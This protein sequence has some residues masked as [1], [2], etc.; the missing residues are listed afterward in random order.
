MAKYLVVKKF[1]E[2]VFGIET[3]HTEIS[4]IEVDDDVNIVSHWMTSLMIEHETDGVLYTNPL[5]VENILSIDFYLLTKASKVDT[6]QL[7]DLEKQF[8]GIV[9]NNKSIRDNKGK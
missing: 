8:D 2:D 7:E 3:T 5:K 9:N 4:E 6:M 1:I